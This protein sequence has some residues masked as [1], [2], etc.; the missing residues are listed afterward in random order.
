MI[1]TNIIEVTKMD[2]L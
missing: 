2:P 1:F